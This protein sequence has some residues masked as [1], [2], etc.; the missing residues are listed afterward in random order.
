AADVEAYRNQTGL[1]DNFPIR[2]LRF[3]F[4]FFTLDW[5]ESIGGESI[6]K[7]ILSRIPVTLSLT[8]FSIL[9]SLLISLP[10]VFFSLRR[11]GRRSPLLSVLSSSFYV[12]PTFV[13]SII[14][15][16]VFSLWLKLFPVAGYKTLKDGILLHIRSLFLPSL[17]LAL[18]H[19][20]LFM[21][22]L[23][24]ALEESLSMPYTRTALSKGVQEKKLVVSSAMKPVLPIFITLISDGI[25]QGLGGSVV[26]ESVFA[27]PGIGSLL[28]RGAVQRDPLLVGATVMV[29]ASLISLSFLFSD[30]VS[31]L[32]D[33]RQRRLDEK[34]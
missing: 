9:L 14:L 24:E 17:A 29:T 16:I 22:M 13:S 34:N 18:L 28:V 8:F 11:M 31:Y 10:V 25:A 5:G 12:L 3:L 27:L 30:I 20:S 6:R 33:P 21:R 32:L 26:V 2:Y 4:S 23:A 15:V 19:S 1:D 7:M